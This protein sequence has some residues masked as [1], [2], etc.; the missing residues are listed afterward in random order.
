[1]TATLAPERPADH[2]TELLPWRPEYRLGQPRMDATHEEFAVLLNAC[3]AAIPRGDAQALAAFD[4][5]RQHTV[6]HFGQEDRWMLDCGFA[7]ENCHSR[8]HA[9]VLEVM[10]EVLRL[11]R[12]E[13]RF[14]PLQRIV[15][16][17]GAW[18]PQ[19]AEMMD[20]ALAARIAEVGY[21][22]AAGGPCAH[23]HAGPLTTGCGG[24][25]CGD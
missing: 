20:A 21:D 9:Q 24:S 15:S 6:G 14:D 19:H 13:G 4:A 2:A 5:L 11:G 3:A 1:M 23:P 18:F 8:Q 22:P 10:D 17:L 25:R 12:E 7:A 16:E